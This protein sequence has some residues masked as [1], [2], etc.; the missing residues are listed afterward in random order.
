MYM[1]R[2]FYIFKLYIIESFYIGVIFS[3]LV[4]LN[5]CY[6]DQ[7][8]TWF[9]PFGFL[10]GQTYNCQRYDSEVGLLNKSS[11]QAQIV[12]VTKFI[13]IKGMI[14]VTLCCAT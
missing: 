8:C 6:T 7:S 5:A 3:I 10:C 14:L 1:I 2:S 12:G 9:G 11:C 13:N 4:G